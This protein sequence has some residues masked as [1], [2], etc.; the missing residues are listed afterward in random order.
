M[1]SMRSMLGARA[2]FSETVMVAVAVAE[3]KPEEKVAMDAEL[4]GRKWI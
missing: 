3:T 2:L 1:R 4:G